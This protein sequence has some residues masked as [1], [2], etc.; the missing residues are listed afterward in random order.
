M[1]LDLFSAFDGSET[2]DEVHAKVLNA[3]AAL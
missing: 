2:V 1:D 3:L